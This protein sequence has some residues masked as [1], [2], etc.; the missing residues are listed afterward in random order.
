MDEHTLLFGADGTERVVAVDALNKEAKLFIRTPLGVRSEQREWSP[1][2]FAE[3]EHPLRGARWSEVAA[4]E[5]GVWLRKLAWFDSLS[6]LHAAREAMQERG[7]PFLAPGSRVR[8]FLTATGITLF[9]GMGYTELHRL[10]LDIETTSLDPREHGAKL[11]MVALCD[12]RGYE[13]VI[14]GDERTIIRRLSQEV[15]RLDP[16]VIE[17][18]NLLAFDLPYLYERANAVEESLVLGRE[19]QTL[20]KLGYARSRSWRWSQW[21][22]YGRHL[23][24][25]MHAIQR[26]DVGRGELDSYGLKQ[27]AA[28]L[29]IAEENR[30]ILD[31]TEM[32]RLA[33]QEPERVREYALQDVRETRSLADLVCATDFYQTQMVP[34][35]YQAVAEMGMGEKINALMHRA[36]LAAGHGIPLPKPPGAVPGGYTEVRRTGVLRPVVK[37]DVQSLYPSIM[38]R[39]E[40]A[41]SSDVLGVFLPMLRELTRRRIEAKARMRETEGQERTYWDGL[42]SSFKVLINSFYGY[43]GANVHFNDPQAAAQV[44]TRGQAIVRRAAEETERLGGKVIEVDTDGIYFVPPPEVAGSLDAEEAFVARVGEA[45][46]EGIHLVHD[47]SFRAMLS[48]KVKNYALQREDGR[49]VF[50]GASLR[51]RADEPF[52][53]DFLSRGVALLL[54]GDRAGLTAL[55]KDTARAILQGELPIEAL[56][57]RERVTE[58]TF[59]SSAKRRAKQAAEGIQ[60][61]VGDYVRVYEAQGGVLKPLSAYSNDENREYYVDKLYKFACRLEPALGEDLPSVFPHPSALKASY[62]NQPSLFEF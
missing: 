29:G 46:P 42:Q 6:D 24:D 13:E 53:R 21:D 23:V 39:F 25:T 28:A 17:G 48:L 43:L 11:L 59:H 30:I 31:R 19:E 4:P 12:N 1:W 56:A 3:E 33:E 15:Q 61:K 8:Q 7:V 38:D 14:A 62:G 51:S 34:E 58:K 40:I 44:T 22:V 20:T 49:L 35:S 37:G 2:M 18:H 26:F 45:L 54:E 36:Y 10:Q 5:K 55:Y 32:Q 9:K 60:A 47:G 57:R 27:A 52:G 16:D 50:H 41:P